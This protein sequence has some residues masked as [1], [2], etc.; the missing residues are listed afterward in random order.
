MQIN[1]ICVNS[2]PSNVSF[3][4]NPIVQ[5]KKNY[6][7]INSDESQKK[8]L[9]GL[10]GLAIIGAATIGTIALKKKNTTPL[11]L[12]KKS[13]SNF[14]ARFSDK[15][16]PDPIIQKLEGRRDAEA[17]KLYKGYRAQ[18]KMESLHNKLLSGQFNK[19]PQ[20]V[21]VCIQKN[22]RKL[23]REAAVVM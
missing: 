4:S 5:K 7:I 8:I 13:F 11:K 12:I 21:F 15:P 14:A 2:K 17:V 3:K 6:S 20:H 22:E 9:I 16:T 19:K 23:R 18:D 10:A 1:R